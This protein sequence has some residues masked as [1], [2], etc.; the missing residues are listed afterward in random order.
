[1]PQFVILTHTHPSLHWDLMLESGDSLRTWRLAE[2]P[3]TQPLS[4]PIKPADVIKAES[5]AD[6]RLAYLTYEGPVSRNRGRVDRWDAGTYE[7]VAET[8]STIT[9]KFRGGKLNGVY[10]FDFS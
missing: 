1:M 10:S 4:H 9:V 5:I 6:H 3:P 2:T 7:L 8:E